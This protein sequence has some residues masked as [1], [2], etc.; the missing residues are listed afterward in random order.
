MPAN[1]HYISTTMEL[2]HGAIDLS[3]TLRT[4]N[5][6]PRAAEPDVYDAAHRGDTEHQEI[7]GMPGAIRTRVTV[8]GVDKKLGAAPILDIALNTKADLLIHPEGN[9][10]GNE[11]ITVAD[12]YLLSAERVFSYQEVTVWTAE[13]F[14][15]GEPDY[16]LVT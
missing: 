4:V 12:A 6:N 7:V 1:E 14:A 5:L 8:V 13:F 16:D 9:T 10:S 3:G 2:K 11:E 15:L